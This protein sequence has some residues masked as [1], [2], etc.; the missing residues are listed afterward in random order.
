ML[1]FFVVAGAGSKM[2]AMPAHPRFAHM[3]LRAQALRAA[4]LGC[5]LAALLSER[6]LFRG[7]GSNSN[8]DQLGADL[9][10]RFRVLAGIGR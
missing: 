10:G 1:L 4:E 9:A 2:N 8:S 3:V 5:M 6:D 7:T